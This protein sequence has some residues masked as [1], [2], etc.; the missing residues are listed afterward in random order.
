MTLMSDHRGRGLPRHTDQVQCCTGDCGPLRQDQQEQSHQQGTRAARSVCLCM[1][2]WGPL[3]PTLGFA[4]AAAGTDW[5]TQQQAGCSM[6][7][8]AY[9]YG[10]GTA[11][12]GGCTVPKG[13]PWVLGPAGLVAEQQAPWAEGVASLPPLFAQWLQKHRGES[14][15]IAC[16]LPA[17]EPHAMPACFGR[18]KPTCREA[19][20]TQTL[21][22]GSQVRTPTTACQ[23]QSSRQLGYARFHDMPQRSDEGNLLS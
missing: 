18:Q 3:W 5:P 13:P 20:C 23:D 17:D 1:P 11:I 9:T 12:D 4:I 14:C 22:V 16:S 6:D 2:C 10:S 21:L 8:L 15:W 19:P 7:P